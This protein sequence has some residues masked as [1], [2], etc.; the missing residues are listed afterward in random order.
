MNTEN[1]LNIRHGDVGLI[2]GKCQVNRIVSR[3][4]D[5]P[6]LRA[7]VGPV[8]FLF[9]DDRWMHMLLLKKVIVRAFPG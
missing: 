5:Q 6:N 8:I 9:K 4:A 3:A 2:G 7:T 1:G